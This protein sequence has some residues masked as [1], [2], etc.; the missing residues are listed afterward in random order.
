MR[1]CS[2]YIHTY[3]H[4][5]ST[6]YIH[7]HIYTYCTIH[8]YIEAYRYV[9]TVHTGIYFC[10]SVCLTA[11]VCLRKRCHE[12]APVN[13]T[14]QHFIYWRFFLHS[15]NVLFS[16]E[17]CICLQLSDHETKIVLKRQPL[18]GVRTCEPLPTH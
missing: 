7:T 4:T 8:T 17:S 3:I 1:N 18:K 2:R 11:I 14:S 6:S 5:N 15:Y 12:F 13:I 16:K 10:A 9:H